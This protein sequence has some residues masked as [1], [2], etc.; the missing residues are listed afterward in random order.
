M[1]VS[2]QTR[3]YWNGNVLNFFDEQLNPTFK[4]GLWK[5]CPALVI[6]CDPSVGVEFFDD[7]F[8]VND[9]ASPANSKFTES[10]DTPLVVVTDAANGVISLAPTAVTNN[11]ACTIATDGESWDIA[12]NKELWFEARVKLTEANTDD[13]NILIGLN[14]APGADVMQDNGAGPP[15]NYDGIS[16]FKLDGGT[17]WKFETSDATVQTT[18]T[19][20]GDFTT[21]TW[22]RVGFHYDGV[23]TVTPYLDGVAGT[24]H[25]VAAAIT[26]MEF[27]ASVKNGDGNKETLLIDYIKI[28]NLR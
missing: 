11:H 3:S 15:A 10:G 13:A 28:V 7:C 20:L 14:N 21:N 19:T 6:L 27:I 16:I 26:E 4:A 24:A 12:T 18:A 17:E 1:A 2:K 9:A 22:H 5:A 8:N 23:T 25:T